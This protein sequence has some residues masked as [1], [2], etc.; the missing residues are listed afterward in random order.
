MQRVLKITWQRLLIEDR[1]CPR[2]NDTENELDKA[3]AILEEKLAPLGWKIV[4]EKKPLT[5]EQFDKAPLSSNLILLN[6]RPI[7]E[8]LAAHTG[9]SPCCD[10]CGPAQC[11]TIEVDEL[12]YETVPADLIVRAALT[13][14]GIV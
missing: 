5:R 3:V 14:A 9:Q 8:Y 2:C 7:E 1:T 4:V 13:A 10:V 12:S 11:R 6:D